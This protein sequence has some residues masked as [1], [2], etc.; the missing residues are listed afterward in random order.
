MLKKNHIK[1]I[2]K[3]L[4]WL[5]HIALLLFTVLFM[6]LSHFAIYD[7]FYAQMSV[8]IIDY[9]NMDFLKML[10]AFWVVS[11]ISVAAIARIYNKVFSVI[12]FLLSQFSIFYFCWLLT[13]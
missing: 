4:S 9:S 3:I 11:N 13:V 8:Y 1:N 2:L 10:W 5:F 12:H 7:V 6:W